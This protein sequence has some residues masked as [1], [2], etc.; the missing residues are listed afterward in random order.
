MSG[1]ARLDVKRAVRA[2]VLGHDAGID[3]SAK[4]EWARSS[5]GAAEEPNRSAEVA[6]PI[7]PD[8]RRAVRSGIPV[9]ARL[10]FH[11]SASRWRE[12]VVGFGS[13]KSGGV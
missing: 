6:S 7:W 11:R 13:Q 8:P 3:P 1:L 9:P 12:R 5:L 2:Y 10:A 4:E